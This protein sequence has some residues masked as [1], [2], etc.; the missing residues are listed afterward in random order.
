MVVEALVLRFIHNHGLGHILHLS[1]FSIN[2]LHFHLFHQHQI[3]VRQVLKLRIFLLETHYFFLP[4][5]EEISEVDLLLGATLLALETPNQ[6]L[7]LF[8]GFFEGFNFDSEHPITPLDLF[9]IHLHD[10]FGMALG[11]DALRH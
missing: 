9:N 11:H 5:D 2:L 8:D 10:V 6:I 7:Q 4:L 1:L 3:F